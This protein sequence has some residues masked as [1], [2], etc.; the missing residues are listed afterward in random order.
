MFV[1]NNHQEPLPKQKG[2]RVWMND[3]GFSENLLNIEAVW[4]YLVA[5][6]VI[7]LNKR[8]FMADKQF[9]N[10]I[11]CIEFVGKWI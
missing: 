11:V 1:P 6:K 4:I 3:K 9:P 8:R 5:V 2:K 7:V 10:E